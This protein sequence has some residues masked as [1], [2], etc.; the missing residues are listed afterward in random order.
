M[1]TTISRSNYRFLYW[2][3][4]QQLAQQT[5]TGCNLRP[6]DLLGSG[7]I[8]GDVS[9]CCRYISCRGEVAHDYHYQPLKLPVHVPNGRSSRRSKPSLAA[10][11]FPGTC[12]A[13]ALSVFS[14]DVSYCCRYLSCRE[15][16]RDNFIKKD[17][18]SNL[19]HLGTC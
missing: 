1:I 14:S 9:Y 12:G 19:Q 13:L 15:V 5:V 17:D 2:T 10:T 3:A 11:C 8:S 7:T 18:Y 4:K 6:G 16:A